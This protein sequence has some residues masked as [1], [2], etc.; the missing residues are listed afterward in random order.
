MHL[1]RSLFSKRVKV[2]RVKK[3]HYT[4]TNLKSLAAV[5]DKNSI[6]YSKLIRKIFFVPCSVIKIQP[7]FKKNSILHSN[8]HT[9]YNN[10]I[11]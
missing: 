2:R 8:S 1:I 3:Q 10:S 4:V 5:K 9:K 7:F 11:S 6:K